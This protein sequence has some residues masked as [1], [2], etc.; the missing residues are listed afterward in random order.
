MS[1]GADFKAALKSRVEAVT[2]EP[3]TPPEGV[4]AL[5]L[6]ELASIEVAPDDTIEGLKAR[7]RARIESMTLNKA[8]QEN[9]EELRTAFRE[10]YAM[11]MSDGQKDKINN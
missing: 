6:A 5:V 11:V 7:I 3:D 2:L 1:T 10:I 8:L 9:F 4:R